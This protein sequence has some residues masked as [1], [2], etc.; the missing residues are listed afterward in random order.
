[1]KDNKL[2]EYPKTAL[3]S[4]IDTLPVPLEVNSPKELD[5]LREPLTEYLNSIKSQ[6]EAAGFVGFA[7][8]Q[9]KAEKVGAAA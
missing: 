1:M 6:A 8:T 5:E 2:A 7:F 9:R 4:V 3:F